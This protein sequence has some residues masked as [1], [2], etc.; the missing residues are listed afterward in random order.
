MQQSMYNLLHPAH[1]WQILPEYDWNFGQY[2]NFDGLSS[3]LTM[4]Q[5]VAETNWKIPAT[6]NPTVSD[7]VSNEPRS[8]CPIR[9]PV[10]DFEIQIQ[11]NNRYSDFNQDDA[12]YTLRGSSGVRDSVGM[13]S[14]P[15]SQDWGKWRSDI[16]SLY[17]ELT[18]EDTMS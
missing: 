8:I 13:I 18:L 12:G 4:S 14:R 15:I 5:G 6:I 3:D 11:P 10:R 9:V 16:E 17:S 7:L 1:N 2:E